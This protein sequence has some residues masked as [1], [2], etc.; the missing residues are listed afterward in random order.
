MRCAVSKS[1]GKVSFFKLTE[2][3]KFITIDLSYSKFITSQG[4]L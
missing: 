4:K 2:A 1:I 3:P